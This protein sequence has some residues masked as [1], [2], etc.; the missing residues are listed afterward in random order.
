MAKTNQEIMEHSSPLESSEKST[1]QQ[2]VKASSTGMLAFVFIAVLIS[3]LAGAFS[4]FLFQKLEENKAQLNDLKLEVGGQLSGKLDGVSGKFNNV[5]DRFTNVSD[6]ISRFNDE[7]SK[8]HNSIKQQD[9]TIKQQEGLFKQQLKQYDSAL[10][11]QK[12]LIDNLQQ[13]MQQSKRDQLISN[14]QLTRSLDMLYKQKGKTRNDWILSEVEYLLLIANHGLL[15][16]FDVNTAIIALQSADERLLDMGDP[17]IINIRK[18]IADELIQLR[19]VPVVDVP[20]M[21]L[22]LSSMIKHVRSLA[23]LDSEIPGVEDLLQPVKIPQTPAVDVPAQQQSKLD[24]YKQALITATNKFLHEL[25][26]LVVYRNKKIAATALIAPEQKFFLQQHVSLKLESARKALL[27]GK[28][29]LFHSLLAETQELLKEFFDSE[30]KSVQAFTK[31]L[32]SLQS[33]NLSRTLPDISF[34][35][36]ELKKYSSQLDAHRNSND[37]TMSSAQTEG[38]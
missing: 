20:G 12:G 21:Q 4:F 7:I 19:A 26:N 32:T 30:K 24:Q 11:V 33:Q 34:S 5:T 29:E 23:V 14:E 8:I 18:F 15:L 38:E 1:P 17:G 10:N 37:A 3:V 31:Q 2:V 35:L 13:S 22:T 6:R 27:D 36:K 9:G 25:K 28:N 16:S